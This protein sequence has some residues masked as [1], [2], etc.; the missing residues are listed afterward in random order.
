MNRFED[1]AAAPPMGVGGETDSD[2][3]VAP[4]LYWKGGCLKLPRVFSKMS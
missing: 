3:Y 1:E 2:G 4:K